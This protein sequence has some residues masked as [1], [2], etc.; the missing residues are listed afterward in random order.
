M[1]LK[2][3]GDRAKS[4]GRKTRVM[5]KKRESEKGMAKE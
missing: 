5:G 4:I 2:S 1:N 3:K